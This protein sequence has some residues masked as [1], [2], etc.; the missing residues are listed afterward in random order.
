MT[1]T[2]DTDTRPNPLADSVAGSVGAVMAIGGAENA[3]LMAVR[4]LALSDRRLAEALADHA[5]ALENKA[6]AQDASLNDRTEG[7]PT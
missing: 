4:M 2:A 7:P 1:S 6:I 3:G 5:L